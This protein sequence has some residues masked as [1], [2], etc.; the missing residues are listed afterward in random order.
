M[1]KLKDMYPDA[2]WNSLLNYSEY[3]VEL[4]N[5]IPS[6][7][8][9]IQFNTALLS[10]VSSLDLVQILSFLSSLIRAHLHNAWSTSNTTSKRRG[11]KVL[12]ILSLIV[13]RTSLH[14]TSHN[15]RGINLQH[16]LS[17]WIYSRSSGKPVNELVSNPKN[18]DSTPHSQGYLVT[19]RRFVC[20]VGSLTEHRSPYTVIYSQF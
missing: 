5:A 10:C 11:I 2:N 7:L 4:H 20:R 1:L 6:S 17:R 19:S 18:P 16:E 3:N 13:F 12:G 14:R 9:S 8:L 15:V